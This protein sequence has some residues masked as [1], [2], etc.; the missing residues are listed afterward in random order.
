MLLLLR[1]FGSDRQVERRRAKMVK[2]L[3]IDRREVRRIVIGLLFVSPWIIGFLAWTIYP[4][5]SALYYSFTHYDVIRP[6]KFVGLEN[7]Q[8]MLTGDDMFHTVLANTLWFVVVSVPA[9]VVTAFLLAILLNQ[10]IRFRPFFRTLFFLPSIT[11]AVASVMV[12]LWIYN[13]QFG[14]INGIMINLGR[15]VIPWLSSPA[16][17]KPSL[18][19]VQCWMQGTAMVI[20]LA[21][22]QDVPRSLYDAALVDGANRLQ[23]LR[24]VTIPMVSPVVL[25]VML[26]SLIGTFQSFLFPWLLTDGGPNN[27]TE[28]YSVYLYR[29]AFRHFKMGYASALGWLLLIIIVVFTASIFRTSARWVYYGG[30]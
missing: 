8:T 15:P 12:W 6:A 3:N 4:M 19:I 13:T 17:A 21:A 20:F 22:L 16:M 25:F 23:R 30:E 10:K 7:Y 2:N 28:L 14:L 1:S 18:V 27:S 5:G 26:T 9:G 11:P 24:H 29:S